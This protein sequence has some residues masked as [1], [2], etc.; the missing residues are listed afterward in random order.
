MAFDKNAHGARKSRRK[1]CAFCVEKV[2]T[3]D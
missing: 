2:D 3:I 1:V